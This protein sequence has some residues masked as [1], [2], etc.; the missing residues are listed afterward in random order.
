MSGTQT[1]DG[2]FYATGLGSCGITNQ[3]SEDICAVSMLLYDV[4]PGYKGGDPNSNPVCGQRIKA[5]YQG[6]SVVV[7]V[8]DRCTGCSQTSL[9]FSP[10][11]FNQLADPSVGRIHGV[12]WEWVDN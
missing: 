8:T 10:H 7:K 12:T 3:D 6:K 11:A 9:D 5:T 1:G 4:Y 2:T